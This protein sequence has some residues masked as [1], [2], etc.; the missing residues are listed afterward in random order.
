[1]FFVLYLIKRLSL[2]R[3]SVYVGFSACAFLFMGSQNYQINFQYGLPT[4]NLAL[5]KIST[6]QT[7][8]SDLP[9]SQLYFRDKVIHS[10]PPSEHFFSETQMPINP[11]ARESVYRLENLI[12]SKL[13]ETE[14]FVFTI[15]ES[16]TSK[17]FKEKENCREIHKNYYQVYK[18][19]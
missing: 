14:F 19:Q 18:C 1:M 6:H 12:E 17:F 16:I 8:I 2:D 11:N 10:Y 13:L 7:L 3:F 15:E 4:A 9:S 5:S